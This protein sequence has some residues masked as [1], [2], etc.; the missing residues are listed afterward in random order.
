MILDP[1]AGSV[2]QVGATPSAPAVEPV[3]APARLLEPAASDAAHAEVR[4]REAPRQARLVRRCIQ[5]HRHVGGRLARD[6]ARA[7]RPRL[8]RRSSQEGVQDAPSDPRSPE[9]REGDRRRLHPRQRPA[10]HRLRVHRRPR[11]RRDDRRKSFRA[12]G[13][14]RACAPGGVR[15]RSPPRGGRVPLR[16]QAPQPA[17]DRARREDHRLQC[18]RLR[19][20]R[21][22]GRRLSSLHPAGPRPRSCADDERS[23]GSRPLRAGH[24]A[25]RGGD[26]ALSVGRRADPAAGQ[27]R[28]R[29]AGAVEP[30][31]PRARARRHHVEGD[32]AQAR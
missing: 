2:A 5:G 23:R 12:R 25:L 15:P 27:D 10:L 6:E 21:G 28:R 9:R 29:P 30:D 19:R 4:R 17:V 22:A 18:V 14:A 24:H 13:R 7:A 32:R 3:R 26:R 16:H 8:D 31:E 1:S 20:R 11:R